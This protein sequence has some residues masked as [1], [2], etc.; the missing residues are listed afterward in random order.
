MLNEDYKELIKEYLTSKDI[1][2]DGMVFYE[3]DTNY[4]F[5]LIDL[6]YFIFRRTGR[7]DINELYDILMSM[8][9]V[10]NVKRKMGRTHRV[11]TLPKEELK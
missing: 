5:K 4:E 8:N 11:V 6:H 3:N 7:D 10:H 2:R 9:C 1:N